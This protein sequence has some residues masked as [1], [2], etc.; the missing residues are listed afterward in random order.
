MMTQ[1]HAGAANDPTTDSA[2]GLIQAD[3]AQRV[4]FFPHERNFAGSTNGTILV[5]LQ[6]YAASYSLSAGQKCEDENETKRT[7]KWS[8][9]QD[10]SIPGYKLVAYEYRID[11]GSRNLIA[12]YRAK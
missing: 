8:V 10:I 4:L 11:R 6:K 7:S 3:F 2:G 12:Y 9:L 1:S 5:C